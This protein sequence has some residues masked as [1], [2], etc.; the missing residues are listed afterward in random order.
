MNLTQHSDFLNVAGASELTI[1]KKQVLKVCE[2]TC[3]LEQK[4]CLNPK[5]GRVTCVI[6]A[7]G[8]MV[9]SDGQFQLR[10]SAFSSEKV[11]S[12]RIAA[13][14]SW[15]SASYGWNLECHP[16]LVIQISPQSLRSYVKS[17]LLL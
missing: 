11:L 5:I 3:S 12:V 1:I 8:L 15:S 13:Q 14:V 6:R 17:H 2:P 7:G 9:S 16:V 4:E 10:P